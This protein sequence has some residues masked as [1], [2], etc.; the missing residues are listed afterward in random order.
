ME[1]VVVQLA[2]IVQSIIQYVSIHDHHAPFFPITGRERTNHFS[3]DLRVSART[4]RRTYKNQLVTT[5]M[6]SAFS[7]TSKAT[8]TSKTLPGLSGRASQVG[9]CK[10]GF[11]RKSGSKPAHG[12]IV[13]GIDQTWSNDF[14][15]IVD[16]ADRRWYDCDTIVELCTA[17]D[18]CRLI[19][20]LGNANNIAI[21][22][23]VESLIYDLANHPNDV[24][25][26]QP[27]AH[28]RCEIEA[29]FFNQVNDGRASV[30]DLRELDD[31]CK[32]EQS[33]LGME[34]LRQL[35][36]RATGCVELTSNSVVP[37]QNEVRASF[38]NEGG[39]QRCCRV[40]C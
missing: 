5:Q 38:P 30:D 25:T 16:L 20:Q 32:A 6:A 31:H 3:W 35:F 17:L 2:E 34:S 1:K 10:S 24:S 28:L 18:C 33:C 13:E 8:S 4:T 9:V 14:E 39:P 11:A 21:I 15:T 22:K 7:A 37:Y 27:D 26:G 23:T 29:F 19:G 36:R 40:C 12:P